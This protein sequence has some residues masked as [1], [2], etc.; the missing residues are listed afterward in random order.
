MPS[1]P[2]NLESG[3][4]QSQLSGLDGLRAIGAWLVVAYHFGIPFAP[5]GIGVLIFFVLSGFLI[6]W[7]LIKEQDRRGTVSLRDFYARRSLRIFP[8]FYAYCACVF[9][10][11]VLRHHPII[12]PQ[13]VSSLLYV[14]NYYHA[15]NGDPNTGFSHTWSL[16]IEEQFYLLWPLTFLA[17]RGNY[18]RMVRFLLAAIGVV[19]VYRLTLVL[20]FHV[21]QGY[22]YEAFDTRADHLLIGCLLAIALRIGAWPELWRRI[23]GSTWTALVVASLLAASGMAEWIYESGYR[24]TMG[25][26]IN[27]VLAAILIAQ[28]IALREVAPWNALNWNWVRYLGRLSYSTY[29]YQQL[30]V[31]LPRKMIPTSPLAVQAAVAVALVA[32]AASVS[33]FAIE[34]PFLRLKERFKAT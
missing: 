12:W 30:L 22:I 34:R 10:V 4:R 33:Y 16:G 7:L 14:N 1:L 31:E 6:T 23:C 21:F 20:V 25:F 13:A 2:K 15:I 29:L 32:G 26:V 17:F 28:A 19:W 5:G 9:A 3:L 18:R 27:P 8:A 11:A 24:D